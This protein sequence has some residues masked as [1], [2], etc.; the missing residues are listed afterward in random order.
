MTSHTHER[1]LVE[2]V[3]H[4]DCPECRADTERWFVDTRQWRY[5]YVADYLNYIKPRLEAIWQGV[6]TLEARQWLRKYR[7]AADRRISLKV[8]PVK[9]ERKRSDSFLER[10]RGLSPDTPNLF[11][12]ASCLDY[13]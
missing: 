4:S 7:E 12:K 3:S 2:R 6:D 5:K 11:R 9:A 10:L 1:H 13:Y 8:P